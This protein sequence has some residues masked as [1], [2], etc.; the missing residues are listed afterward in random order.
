MSTDTEKGAK[1]PKVEAVEKIV[2]RKVRFVSQDKRYTRQP[3]F[4]TVPKA[5]ASQR[6]VTGQEHILTEKQMTGEDEKLL[7]ADK[8]ALQMGQKPYIINPDNTYPCTHLRTHDLSYKVTG[9]EEDDR[10]YINPRDF[11]EYNFFVAQTGQVCIGKENYQVNKHYFYVED[12]EKE[13]EDELKAIDSRYEA[14]KFVRETLTSARH[15]DV[16]LLLNFEVDGFNMDPKTMSSTLITATVLK[17]C[18]THPDTILKLQKK[19]ATQLMFVLKLLY[20]KMIER[21]NN[22]DFYAG[23]TFIGGNLEAVKTYCA[24]SENSQLVTKWGV[25]IEQKERA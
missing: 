21:R 17:H 11:A 15:K 16:I 13:S 22:I 19:D 14:E 20:H 9:D 7:P 12:K 23:E 4:F 5:N 1:A 18:A 6:H 3:Y 24:R 25:L 2:I 8:R 10:E